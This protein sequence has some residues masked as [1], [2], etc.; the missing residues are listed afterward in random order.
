MTIL[1]KTIKWLVD[2][3]DGSLVEFETTED[4]K[5]LLYVK[6]LSRPI[7]LVFYLDYEY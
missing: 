3:D 4:G 6:P 5:E 2:W 1:R 7:G